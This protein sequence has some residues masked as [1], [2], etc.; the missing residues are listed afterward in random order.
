MKFVIGCVTILLMI[1]LPAKELPAQTPPPQNQIW[2]TPN[3]ASVDMLEMFTAPGKWASAITKIDVFKFYLV[4]AGTG[5]WSCVGHPAYNCGESHL[6]NLVNVKAF[7]RLGRWGIDIA[8]ESFFAGPIMSYDP[9]ECSTAEHVFNLTLD[10]SINVI[11][12][13]QANG[14][15]FATWRWMSP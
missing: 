1:I 8:V 13:V 11:Q 9:V 10:G 4:Q 7:S 2:F 12:N 5:G 14:E 6:E 3:L 15:M